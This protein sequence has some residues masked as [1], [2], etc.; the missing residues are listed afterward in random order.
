MH[1]TCGMRAPKR[2]SL[3]TPPRATETPPTAA[4]GAAARPRTHTVEPQP[5]AATG[6]SVGSP[7]WVG[8]GGERVHGCGAAA[9]TSAL[10]RRGSSLCARGDAV[11]VCTRARD[12][13][14]SRLVQ[15]GGSQSELVWVS[16]R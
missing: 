12:D 5:L 16:K 1:G 14:D 8:V 15:C 10:R 7:A 2:T 4:A 13:V 9:L 3:G 11:S 6:G